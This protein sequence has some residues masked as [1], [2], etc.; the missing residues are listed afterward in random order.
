[1]MRKI[2]LEI[3]KIS[4]NNFKKQYADEKPAIDS[5]VT[6]VFQSG[7]Y[8]LGPEVESFEKSFASY[9]GAKFAVGVANGLEALQISLLALGIGPG[10][11][12]ITTSLSAVATTLSIRALG[13]KPVFVDID[14]FYHIDANKVEAKISKKTKAIMPVHLYGQACDMDKLAAIAKKHDLS[15]I[16]DCAQ[17]HGATYGKHKV[18]TFG[19][20]GCFSFYPTKNLGAF[21]DAGA[22][23]TDDAR[24]ADKC[25]MI[26][27]YGQRTRYEHEVYGINSRLDE[28]QAAILSVLLPKL[29]VNNSRRQKIALAYSK[30]L[31]QIKGLTLPETRAKAEHMYHL[32]VIRTDSRDELQQFLKDNEVDSLIHYPIP[33][34]KQKCFS[35]YNNL[36]LPIT[37][38]KAS[39]ILSLP[40]N[41]QLTDEEVNYVCKIITNFFKNNG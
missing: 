19:I 25:H 18:G 33:I 40:V 24:F 39:K 11:E 26:R 16:E 12:V 36:S 30:A 8:I 9:N 10:D 31:A 41:P 4:F 35:E 13:A 2:I 3:M 22:I 38:E 5:A 7:R 32:F 37:E 28:V 6:R 23:I 15:I 20:A 17:A 1:M 34:H 21:G 29:D 27:N 14:D